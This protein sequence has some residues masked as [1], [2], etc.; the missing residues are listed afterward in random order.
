ML[1]RSSLEGVDTR[2]DLKRL[3]LLYEFD[4]KVIDPVA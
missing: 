2:K 4:Y 1:S 3:V